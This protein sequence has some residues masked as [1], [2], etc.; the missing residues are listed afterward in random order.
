MTE[1]DSVNFS[2]PAPVAYV[3]LRN[4]ATG[5]VLTDIPLLIDTGAD[6][7]LLP[8][9]AVEKLGVS[10]EEGSNFEVQVFDGETKFLKFAK[11]DVLVFDKTF[12]GEFLLIDRAIGI[13]G[14]NIL[15]NVRVLFDGPRKEWNEHKR[16]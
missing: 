4:P 15:N 3:T 7:T 16:E 14:R 6:A 5:D 12:K 1:Y 9:A 10:I 11:L 13:L 2:P 8:S